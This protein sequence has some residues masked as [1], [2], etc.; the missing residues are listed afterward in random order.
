MT[1]FTRC[2]G[3]GGEG[4]VLE[5]HLSMKRFLMGVISSPPSHGTAISHTVVYQEAKVALLFPAKFQ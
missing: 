2:W 5:M 3:A 1:Y 4:P